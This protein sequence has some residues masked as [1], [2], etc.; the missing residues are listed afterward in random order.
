M[1]HRLC[2]CVCKD[3]TPAPAAAASKP[4][5]ADADNSKGVGD[6]DL[7]DCEQPL[8]RVKA[9]AGWTLFSYGDSKA[10]LSECVRC[11][12]VGDV[13]SVC[14]VAGEDNDDADGTVK[15]RTLPCSC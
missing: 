15:V 6:V 3:D 9:H 13:T 14:R 8:A 12:R 4:R 2:A 10:T 1:R 7:T 11:E 5:A